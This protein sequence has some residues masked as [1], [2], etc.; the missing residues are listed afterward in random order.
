MQ[1]KATNAVITRTPTEADRENIYAM[2]G[3]AFAPSR[4][5]SKLV[6]RLHER[7]KDLLEWV[8]DDA[9]G[10]A[11]HIAYTQAFRDGERIGW[12]LAPLAVRPDVQRTGLGSRLIRESL[13]QAPLAC[14]PVF[15]LGNPVFWLCSGCGAGL[16]VRRRPSAFPRARLGAKRNIRRWL[17]A[18]IFR[19]LRQMPVRLHCRTTC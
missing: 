11:A 10:V 4:Y 6:R 16:P 12:H 2:L 14:A 18:R 15:V 1:R 3:A 8:L 17:R 19:S 7:K 5:E 9:K 13:V